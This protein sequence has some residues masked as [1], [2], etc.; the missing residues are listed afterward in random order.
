[1]GSF[2]NYVF[3]SNRLTSKLQQRLGSICSGIDYQTLYQFEARKFQYSLIMG[4]LRIV[5]DYKKGCDYL[6]FKFGRSNCNNTSFYGICERNDRHPL[7]QPWCCQYILTLNEMIEFFGLDNK[8]TNRNKNG[9]IEFLKLMKITDKC[10]FKKFDCNIGYNSN[11][12]KIGRML[13]HGFYDYQKGLKKRQEM[14]LRSCNHRNNKKNK[15]GNTRKKLKNEDKFSYLNYICEMMNLSNVK[16]LLEIL[17]ESIENAFLFA[18]KYPQTVLTHAY[19]DEE[20]GNVS[21]ELVLLAEIFDS[22]NNKYYK[23]G[24]PIGKCLNNKTKKYYYEAKNILTPKMAIDN[25]RLNS[26]NAALNSNDWVFSMNDFNSSFYMKY[27][28][29]WF[30]MDSNDSSNNISVNN[31]AMSPIMITMP[32]LTLVKSNDSSLSISSEYSIFSDNKS[33]PTPRSILSTNTSIEEEDDNNSVFSKSSSQHLN[34]D[35]DSC[36]NSCE[37]SEETSSHIE[38]N[39]AKPFDFGSL[40]R[41]SIDAALESTPRNQAQSEATKQ[42]MDSNYLRFNPFTL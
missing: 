16:E 29:F 4:D 33:R 8:N 13:K 17:S 23:F 39:P 6:V 28:P 11:T 27:N 37:E 21:F 38:Q 22:F 42:N 9:Q 10:V 15:N 2:K 14:E 40:R 20:S 5:K 7:K 19:I 1:M 30:N 3:F 26:K 34:F 18:Q 31:E 12:N 36:Y 24:V 35:F 25:I 41:V 32:S